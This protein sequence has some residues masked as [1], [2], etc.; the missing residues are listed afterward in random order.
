MSDFFRELRRKK[1]AM[2]PRS[3]VEKDAME[4]KSAVEKEE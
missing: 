4:P 2:E 1:K 3:A